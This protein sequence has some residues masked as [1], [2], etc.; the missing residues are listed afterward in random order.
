MHLCKINLQRLLQDIAIKH[1]IW[2]DYGYG[3]VFEY[4]KFVLNQIRYYE[5]G[6]C[7]KKSI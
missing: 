5:T 2:V 7:I 3:I 1:R 6:I 4:V